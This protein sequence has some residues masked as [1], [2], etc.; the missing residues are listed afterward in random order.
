MDFLL[1]Y[2]YNGPKKSSK[3][4]GLI[5]FSYLCFFYMSAFAGSHY[6]PYYIE[7]GTGQIRYG[8]KSLLSMGGNPSAGGYFE[9]IILDYL[10]VES[11]IYLSIKTDG[12]SPKRNE[13]K[14]I[15]SKGNSSTQLDLYLFKTISIPIVARFYLEA[16]KR[17]SYFFGVSMDLLISAQKRTIDH[18]IINSKSSIEDVIGTETK[19][20]LFSDEYQDVDKTELTAEG[21]PLLNTIGWYAFLGCSYETDFGLILGSY[22]AMK[23][24][25]PFLNY[26][27]DKFQL[28]PFFLSPDFL[29]IVIGYNVATLFYPEQYRIDD[30]ETNR[31]PKYL[32][33]IQESS[34][35]VDHFIK[36]GPMVGQNICAGHYGAFMEYKPVDRIGLVIGFNWGYMSYGIMPSDKDINKIESGNNEKYMDTP[37]SLIGI[38]CL[39]IPIVVKAYFRGKQFAPLI[40]IRLSVLTSARG[41]VDYYLNTKLSKVP[42]ISGVIVSRRYSEIERGIEGADDIHYNRIT[43]IHGDKENKDEQATLR[44]M[45]I[46]CIIGFEYE[47]E[48]GFILGLKYDRPLSSFVN[49]R[50]F[51]HE[52]F[53]NPQEVGN[54]TFMLELG[55]N[56]SSLMDYYAVI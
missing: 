15:L 21:E 49:L 18:V 20:N 3:K 40:G 12:L 17:S 38:S 7:G 44:K 6:T 8:I 43:D 31:I 52:G 37:V 28:L 55:Y 47:T 2:N 27:K 46:A 30:E 24:S 36:F 39:S 11:G 25:K 41:G 32:K 29:G 26:D 22:Y 33:P 42:F 45:Q 4:L 35:F 14:N 5:I 16:N 13:I 54:W 48:D 9:Y 10:A 50:G 1:K 53:T 19:R 51:E 56:F 23:L 34:Y